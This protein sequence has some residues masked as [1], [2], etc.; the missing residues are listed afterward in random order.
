MKV[1][2]FIE[3]RANAAHPGWMGGGTFTA[4]ANLVAEKQRESYASGLREGI[5]LMG[6]FAEWASPDFHYDEGTKLWE[7]FDEGFIDRKFRWSSPELIEL[8][9]NQNKEI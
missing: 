3:D 1:E 8:F 9:L 5:E 6:E 2:Q 7:R 4:K